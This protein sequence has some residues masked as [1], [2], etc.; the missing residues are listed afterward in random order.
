MFM[1]KRSQKMEDNNNNKIDEI[2]RYCS[3]EQ[4]V[5]I[6]KQLEIPI[7]HINMKD[8]KFWIKSRLTQM[9]RLTLKCKKEESR[10]ED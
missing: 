10:D 5:G 7:D 8:Y 9:I 6:C 2:L 3:L 4:L 1:E